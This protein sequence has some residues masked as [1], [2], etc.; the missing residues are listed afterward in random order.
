MGRSQKAPIGEIIE[1]LMNL[2]PIIR[3][4]FSVVGREIQMNMVGSGPKL[5]RDKC[6]LMSDG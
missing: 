6:L 4:V 1:Y 3:Y 5:P 2:H